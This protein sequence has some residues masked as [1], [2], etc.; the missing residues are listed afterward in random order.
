MKKVT[1]TDIHT[2]GHVNA[3]NELYK[4]IHY[5][6]M[7]NRYD[8][9]FIEFKKM[10]S[11]DEFIESADYLRA[12]HLE[13]GQKHVKFYLPANEKPPEELNEYLIEKDYEVGF[14]ELYAINPKE[15]PKVDPQESIDIEVVTSNNFPA[16]LDFQFQTDLEFG[17]EFAKQKVNLYKRHFTNPAIMQIIAFYQGLPAGTVEVIIAEET[18]EIDGLSVKEDFQKKGIGTRLQQFV[19]DTFADKTIILVADGEDTPRIMYQKQ[20]YHYIGFQYEIQK[21]DSE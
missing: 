12:F 6:E 9:N 3:E 17:K 2:V 15:F 21:I 5:P 8:S 18:A 16:F 20:N 1:F 14:I 11:L 10:P 13:N 4:Q 7:L 19:M